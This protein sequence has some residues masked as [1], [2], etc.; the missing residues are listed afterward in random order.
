[1]GLNLHRINIYIFIVLTS[2]LC[3]VMSI[4][5]YRE[6]ERREGGGDFSTNETSIFYRALPDPHKVWYPTSP[7][8][9][10]LHCAFV[11]LLQPPRT[12][13]QVLSHLQRGWRLQ[14]VI[15]TRLLQ[16]P[17]ST[18]H[19]HQPTALVRSRNI[20]TSL[21]PTA[22]ADASQTSAT[23]FCSCSGRHVTWSRALVAAAALVTTSQ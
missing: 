8:K 9:P 17:T 2:F 21:Q 22:G 1:M 18:R 16:L 20:N 3:L 12:R 19:Q 13:E 7:L 4:G 5:V 11:A 6:K 10:C 15:N 14:H 23:A